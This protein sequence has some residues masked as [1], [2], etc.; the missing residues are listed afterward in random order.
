MSRLAAGFALLALGL[1]ALPVHALTL[2][3]LRWP[4]GGAPNLSDVQKA[5]ADTKATAAAGRHQNDLF[6]RH[7]VCDPVSTGRFSCQID[8]VRKSEPGGRLYFTVVTLEGAP[9]RWAMIGGLCQSP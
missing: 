4:D 2:P 7:A 9:R 8:F 1:S 6:I 3:D 5:Y